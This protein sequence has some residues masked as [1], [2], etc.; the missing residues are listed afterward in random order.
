[1][2]SPNG[3]EELAN[4]VKQDG[5]KVFLLWRTGVAIVV[6]SIQPCQRLS[7]TNYSPLFE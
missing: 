7:E 1:M 6:I 4:L 5:K 2:I 3:L